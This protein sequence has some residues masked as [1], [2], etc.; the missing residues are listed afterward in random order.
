M[1]TLSKVFYGLLLPSVA[2][3]G[4]TSCL[5]DEDGTEVN[6]NLVASNLIIPD[7]ASHPVIAQSNA[8]YQL[9]YK[10]NNSSVSIATTDLELNGGEVS[11]TSSEMKYLPV[12]AIDDNGNP[13][14]TLSFSG[15][16]ASVIGNSGLQMTDLSG[17]QT[18]YVYGLN[19]VGDIIKGTVNSPIVVMQYKIGAYTVKTFQSNSY[20][21]GTTKTSYS[22]RGEEQIYVT[23]DAFYR[24]Q[25]S[26]DMKKADVVLYNVK[27]AEIMPKPIQ[28]IYIRDIPVVWSSAGYHLTVTDYIPSMLEGTE[29]TPVESRKFNSFELW[30]TSSDLTEVS[31]KYVVAESYKGEFS[32]R[33]CEVLKG[34]LSE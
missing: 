3:I 1:N 4:L 10:S 15:G 31:C 33:Y 13:V 27:F 32:G 5:S 20:F 14:Q 28:A 17:C 23:E 7:D 25:F 29:V 9:T 21:R 8:N 34:A 12:S 16:T 19:I 26:K 2:I 6:Y 18:N 30:T 22:M 11:F 24:V